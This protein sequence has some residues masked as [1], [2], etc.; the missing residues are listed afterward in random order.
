MPIRKTWE[1]LLFVSEH[2]GLKTNK[3]DGLSQI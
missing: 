1:R 3:Q 2:L